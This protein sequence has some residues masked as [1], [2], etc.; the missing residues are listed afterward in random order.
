MTPCAFERCVNLAVFSLL[1]LAR[2]LAAGCISSDMSPE[3][4]RIRLLDLDRKAQVEFRHSEFAQAS[5]DFHQAAC[6]APESIR[7]YYELYANA[8]GAVAAGDFA[9]ARE[10]LQ[11]VDRVRPDHPLPLA[12]LAKVDLI[13]GDIAH[14]KTSLAAAGRRFPHDGRLHAQLAQDLLHEKQYDLALAEE[15][16]AGE[17]G[18]AGAGSAMNLAVLENQVGAFGDAARLASAIEEQAG[19]PEKARASGAGIAGLSYESMGQ[20]QDAI[21]H[22]KAASRLDPHQEQPYLALARIYT[23]QQERGAAVVILDQARKTIGSAPNILLALGSAL[24]SA[25]R[26]QAARE[27]LTGLIQ[28]VP[29]QFEAYPKLAEAYRNTGEPSRATET[30]RQLAR[31]KPD[32]PMLHVVIA[33]SLL[34]EEKVDYLGVLQE[35]AAAEKASPG[36]YDV[37]YLRGRVFLA[38]GQFAQAVTSLQRAIQLRPTE[39]GAYYQLGLAYRKLGQPNLAKEQF[40]KLEFLKGA[41]DSLKARE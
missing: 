33:R 40:E 12:M 13:S 24:V 21:R 22:L 36:D 37:Y 34:D 1:A 25:E 14:L 19:L 31:R 30:L 16:R 38:T 6:I 7:S 39:P 11:Q 4:A 2:S 35:L 28:S 29:D 27:T 15:L 18:A 8:T 32:D 9:R 3:Q 10:V 17:S 26:Y 41:P 20:L 23:E 5:E